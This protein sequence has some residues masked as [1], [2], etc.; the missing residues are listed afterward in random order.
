MRFIAIG[1]L[2]GAMAT[3]ALAAEP[4]PVQNAS[5]EEAAAEAAGP[6]AKDWQTEGSP[7]GWH[8]WIGS[9]ARQGKPILTWEETGGRTGDRC[10]SLRGCVGAVCVI[11]TVPV[12]AEAT[13]LVRAWGKTSNPASECTMSVRW[14]DEGGKWTGGTL[15][16]RLPADVPADT[17]HEIE[18]PAPAP[19]GAGRLVILLTASGQSD[20]DKCWFDDVSV[21]KLG[22]R[23][24]L[25]SPCNFM[26]PLLFPTGEPPETPHVKWA[27]PWAKGKLR[28]L[29]LLG[30]DHSL[31]EHIEIAQRMDLDYD[32]TFAHNFEQ[33]LY[34]LNSKQIMRRLDEGYYD[35]AVVAINASE[36]LSRALLD[37]L[38]PDKG[39][40]F[41]CGGNV[42]PSVPADAKFTAAAEDH[43]VKRSVA[44]LPS[45]NKSGEDAIK[46]IE[47]A[48][49]VPGRAVRITYT[50]NFRCLTPSHTYE[51][52]VQWGAG[53]WEGYLQT[54]IRAMLWA[55][56]KAPEAGV[57]MIPAANGASLVMPPTARALRARVW[58]TDRMNRVSGEREIE[59][60]Q[61]AV[62]IQRP[63][64]AASGPAMYSAILTNENGQIF[65]FVSCLSDVK[66]DARIVEV[67]PEKD[68]FLQDEPIRVTVE[69]AGDVAGMKIEGILTDIHGR[70][71]ARALVDAQE[72]I[73]TLSLT[74]RDHLS[75]FNWVHARLLEGETE[76]DTARW[77]VLVPASRE[78][79][80]EDFQVGTWAS[81]GYHPAYLHDAMLQAMKRAGITEGL[82]GRNAYL[83]TLAAG[84]WPVSTAYG[85]APGFSRFKGPETVRE[86][87]LSD[88]GIRQKMAEVCEDVAREE[89]GFSPIFGYL[90]DETSLVP[91]G[92]D[93]DTC[94]SPHCQ[95]RY[96]QWLQERYESLAELNAE[97]RTGY[98][99]WD[100]LGFVDYRQAREDGNL[101]PWLMYRRFMD[102]VWSDAVKWCSQNARKADPTAMLALA[103]SFG[104]NPFSGR[105]YWLLADANDYTME[106]PY[107]AWSSSPVSYHFEAVRSFAGDK[108]HHPWIGY[109]HQEEAINFEPWWCALHGA[110]GVE[111]YGCMSL[112][113]GN[114]SWAQ[115]FPTMQ[116]TKRGKMFADLVTPLKRGIGKAL[117]TA[118]RPQPAIAIL[119]SQPSMYVACG[120][121]GEGRNPR[122][123]AKGRTYHQYF[124][125][126]LAFRQACIASGRQ[127]DYVCE[128]QIKAGVL[129]QFQC[130]VLPASFAIGPEVCG[131]LAEFVERG[132]RLIADQGA[133]LTNEVG[134]RYDDA[135][136]VCELF[137]I[138]RL[139]GKLGYEDAVITYD[140]PVSG[141]VQISAAGHEKLAQV[142]GAPAYEDGSPMIV[143]SKRGKG[144]TMFLNFAA[145]DVPSLRAVFDELPVLALVT[146]D[147]G[148][149]RPTA[150]EIVRLDRGDIHYYG[151][152]RDYRIKE[153]HGPVEVVLRQPDERHLYDVRSGEY[154]GKTDH[155]ALDLA[156]G[157]AALYASVGYEVK[158]ISV[159]GP[160]RARPGEACP[161]RLKILADKQPG[162]HVL[163]IEVTDPTGRR[164]EAY[165]QNLVTRSGQAD[166]EI[167]FA[168][169]NLAGKW[170]IRAQDIASGK[171]TEHIIEVAR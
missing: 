98:K 94:S 1:V 158:G 137:G 109:R 80:L 72:G 40:V 39:V 92:L 4:V 33:S 151:V 160:R 42:K 89:R 10:V 41:V 69:A 6:V 100:E 101:A 51:D 81:T 45:V 136:P 131:K 90:R 104:L 78:A 38:G 83:P 15:K 102:W 86:P 54:I 5:F 3:V 27:K 165:C 117:M 58:V 126:R 60:S 106:Y 73:N 105:D 68:Y 88:P 161:L 36:D 63:L 128:E 65:D 123:T 134:A 44:A 25:V 74:M 21:S 49:D 127:F 166:L 129:D 141:E 97:W 164:A 31:R 142:A 171:A 2:L 93:L 116:L 64:G 23:D 22:P 110:S 13:Y 144:E 130:L 150:Y 118:K 115:V 149:H 132:G 85:R 159:S 47:I 76:R 16:D 70:E 37:K 50:Q 20:A 143:A 107:E 30:S 87:C 121:S 55:A 11:Q 35:V 138:K 135:G 163:H 119:W 120:L 167:P 147:G 99:S 17:W 24:I 7:S 66:S 82:E 19:K 125:S 133:G 18:V 156:P 155:I 71:T 114:S 59:D 62:A 77:Y 52:F 8:H 139:N 124:H 32:Y 168:P 46:E 154:L 43:Y 169:N 103:N 140:F 111:I 95:A 157:R 145:A 53:Y 56:G 152:L 12:E 14:Q 91:G 146:A 122:S 153:E 29:F 34:A 84:L 75:T 148:R 61:S 67:R 108:V 79:F 26:A 113:A 96:R 48:E 9:V 28:A 57:A 170:T 162:D 112:F